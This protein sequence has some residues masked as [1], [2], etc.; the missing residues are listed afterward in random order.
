MEHVYQE[1]RKIKQKKKERSNSF[2]RRLH[3]SVK[4]CREEMDRF[5]HLL[6]SWHKRVHTDLLIGFALLMCVLF[7]FSPLFSSTR[8]ATACLGRCCNCCVPPVVV[9]SQFPP[10]YLLAHSYSDVGLAVSVN[11]STPREGCRYRSLTHDADRF[12]AVHTQCVFR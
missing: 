5:P 12:D 11:V 4:A 8:L 1:G 9:A 6:A 7:F 10:F 3:I 2:K